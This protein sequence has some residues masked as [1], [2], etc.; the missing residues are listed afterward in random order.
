VTPLFAPL[1]RAGSGSPERQR[2]VEFRVRP[3]RSCS[4][5]LADIRLDRRLR[6]RLIV[7]GATA[8][9]APFVTTPSGVYSGAALSLFPS[10]DEEA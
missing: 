4:S 10:G 1:P 8:W 5:G 2:V 6:G 3:R 9:Y 7:L